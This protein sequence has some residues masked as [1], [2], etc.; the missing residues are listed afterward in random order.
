MSGRASSELDETNKGSERQMSV[1]ARIGSKH[2]RS[3]MA[4]WLGASLMERGGLELMTR[5]AKD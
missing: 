1:G 4:V 5:I 2:G 3:S